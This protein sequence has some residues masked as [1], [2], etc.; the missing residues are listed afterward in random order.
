MATRP[1]GEESRL[2]TA[3]RRL[4]GER[5]LLIATTRGPVSLRIDFDPQVNGG[6]AGR[7]QVPC[8]RAM[9]RPRSVRKARFT[10]RSEHMPMSAGEH[11]MAP[12]QI[13][14]PSVCTGTRIFASFSTSTS[15]VS[16]S[17]LSPMKCQ[18][19]ASP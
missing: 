12:K 17:L 18:R 7:Y 15:T 11:P 16:P 5:R 3:A 9:N 6:S 4:L 2:G 1:R 13:T 19:K 14:A 10:P 8:T